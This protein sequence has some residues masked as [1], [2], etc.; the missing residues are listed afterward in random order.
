MEAAAAKNSS[1]LCSKCGLT[2]EALEALQSEKSRIMQDHNEGS[3]LQNQALQTPQERLHETD[4]TR[5]REQESY[6]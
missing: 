5:K 1:W 4:A 3:S 6:K 2:M